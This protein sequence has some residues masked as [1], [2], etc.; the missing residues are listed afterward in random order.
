VS[1]Q[2]GDKVLIYRKVKKAK[3]WGN[4]WVDSMN[5]LVRNVYTVTRL[6][7]GYGYRLSNGIYAF[8]RASL[9]LIAK[10]K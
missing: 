4:S 2:I 7:T 6:D 9:K 8:P 10:K 5:E 1:L 3:N